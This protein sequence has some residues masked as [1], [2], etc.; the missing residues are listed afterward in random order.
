MYVH[1][2]TSREFPFPFACDQEVAKGIQW[3]AWF[4]VGKANL[5]LKIRNTGLKDTKQY[6]EQLLK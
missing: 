3:L 5:N 4:P 1:E 6:S 2:D